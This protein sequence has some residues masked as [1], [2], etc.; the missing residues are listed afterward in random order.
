MKKKAEI[1]AAPANPRR[2]LDLM[3]IVPR[4]SPDMREEE[5]L[6][7]RNQ[8]LTEV[9]VGRKEKIG[10]EVATDPKMQLQKKQ[11]MLDRQKICQSTGNAE[12]E[13]CS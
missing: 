6:L 11:I 5:V 10:E 13:T 7:R 3:L 1:Q 2:N 8:Q 4:Q 9:G 12:E